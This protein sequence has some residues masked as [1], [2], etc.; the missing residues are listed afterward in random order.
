MKKVAM[1]GSI[2]EDGW[3]ILEEENCEVFE[4]NDFS[5][6][7]LMEQLSDV[8]GIALRTAKLDKDILR[9]CPKLKI[10]ARH[11][12]G[13]DS[14]DLNYLNQ[15]KQALAVTGTS[16]AVSVAEHVMTMFLCLAKQIYKSDNFVRS[17]KFTKKMNCP[18]FLNFIKKIFS[19]WGSGALDKL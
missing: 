11:G 1:I 12:V 17:G 2:H 8:D 5:R 3:K 6:K 10:V 9:K 15:N 16:N 13:Y 4:I 14:V 7:N 19:F 18:I